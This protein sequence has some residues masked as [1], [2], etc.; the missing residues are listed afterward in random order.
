MLA[1]SGIEA[2]RGR[3]QNDGMPLIQR[4]AFT[5]LEHV[6]VPEKAYGL[7]RGGGFRRQGGRTAKDAK[8][9]KLARSRP[10][11]ILTGPRSAL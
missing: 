5:D 10:L 7:S 4:L 6:F 1:G 8:V 11:K 3:L 9:Q 2:E